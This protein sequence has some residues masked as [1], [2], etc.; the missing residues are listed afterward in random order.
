MSKEREKEKRPV[1]DRRA[2]TQHP[3]RTEPPQRFFAANG[4]A[5]SCTLA[6]LEIETIDY[7]AGLLRIPWRDLVRMMDESGLVP[8]K[9]EGDSRN[10][11]EPSAH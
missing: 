11:I 5:V 1:L 2:G 9:T 7:H 4:Y 6:G 8:S 3:D 10:S